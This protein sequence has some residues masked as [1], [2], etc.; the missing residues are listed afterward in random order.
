MEYTKTSISVGIHLILHY[1]Q[2]CCV[3]QKTIYHLLIYLLCTAFLLFISMQKNWR[4]LIVLYSLFLFSITTR[5]IP[6]ITS[7][8]LETDSN[9]IY[10]WTSLFSV[11]S[12]TK[13]F[14]ML[15]ICFTLTVTNRCNSSCSYQNCDIL[16]FHCYKYLLISYYVYFFKTVITFRCGA[17]LLPISV[18]LNEFDM[19]C[20]K[21]N[22][23]L[24]YSQ[25]WHECQQY[26]SQ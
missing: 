3:V 16:I 19:L 1:S 21:E 8:V 17:V 2:K 9:G 25:K 23:N 12:E 11:S 7:V 20:G 15:S 18:G 10:R 24:I 14:W 4:L 6:S 5:H 22:I 26:I 13:E